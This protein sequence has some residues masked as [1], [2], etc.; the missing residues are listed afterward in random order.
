M[1]DFPPEKDY[2]FLKVHCDKKK[3]LGGREGYTLFECL[4]WPFV[5]IL[6]SCR[7]LLKTPRPSYL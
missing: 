6:G 1:E 3:G 4:S 7:V 5:S 2:T